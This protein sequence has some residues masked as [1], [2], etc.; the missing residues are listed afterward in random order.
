MS[1]KDYAEKVLYEEKVSSKLMKNAIDILN[2]YVYYVKADLSSDE[3]KQVVDNLEV[4]VE[5]V[6]GNSVKLN[7]SAEFVKDGKYNKK[8]NFSVE[9][10]F[11]G[12]SDEGS[13]GGD[14]TNVDSLEGNE[15]SDDD[16]DIP[17]SLIVKKNSRTDLNEMAVPRL[18]NLQRQKIEYMKSYL[19][20]ELGKD[21][22]FTGDQDVT[23]LTYI[24]KIYVD[25]TGIVLIGDSWRERN[26]KDR[27][28][29]SM[30]SNLYRAC[31]RNDE[32]FYNF[33]IFNDDKDIP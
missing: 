23:M 8:A 25:A 14:I 13:E 5:S 11:E 30:I 12:I 22:I 1:F 15:E 20:S 33:V 31:L 27:I 10:K 2:D 24:K 26:K 19:A 18:T 16:K 3:R 7:G 21:G 4:A 29:P 32:D 9:L 17:E 6:E 28:H